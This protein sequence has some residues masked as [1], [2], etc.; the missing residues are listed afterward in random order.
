MRRVFGLLYHQM[1][2][3]YDA[4]AWLVSGGYWRD[5][6]RTVLVD[7]PGRRVLD[8]GHGTGQLLVDLW[9][10]GY[11]AFGCDL[12][13]AMGR[14][15]RRRLEGHDLPA[16]L[17][18]GRAQQLPFSAGCFDAVVCTF[19]AEFGGKPETLAELERVLAPGG[20]AVVVLAAVP[21]GA[22]R[23]GWLL[24]RLFRLAGHSAADGLSVPT[25]FEV[26]GLRGAAGWV[27]TPG[28]QVLVVRLCKPG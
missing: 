27:P 21:A 15:A 20:R 5:W 3:S 1:A 18:C 2:W 17:V 22:D 23:T 7:L 26:A 24:T 4:V 6:G 10:A 12:S 8:L 25:Q 14:L 28:G 16:R 13:H 19:P 9:T 11:H